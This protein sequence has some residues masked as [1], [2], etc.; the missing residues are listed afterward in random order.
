MGEIDLHAHTTAS[1]GTCTP[2]ELVRRASE[3][4]LRA[5]AVTDHDTIYGHAE[6]ISAGMDYDVEVIPGIEV[7][8][9]Y[10]VSIHI[11]GY[12]IENLIPLL[13]H[14][15]DER[16]R[17]N[18]KICAL[19]SVRISSCRDGSDVRISDAS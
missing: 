3:L 8:T 17:R 2:R 6:A 13:A 4:G 11:L 7:S 12:Y 1:D 16:D 9:K 10:G 5:V 15:V 19:R 14:V 18:K